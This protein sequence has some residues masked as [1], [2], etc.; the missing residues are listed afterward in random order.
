MAILMREDE[1][2]QVKL[3][4]IK[5]TELANGIFYDRQG[6]LPIDIALSPD[7]TMLAVDLVD[8][9][10]GRVNT[11]INFYNFGSVGQ[12]EVDNNVG[13]FTFENILVP[14][15]DYVSKNKMNGV[16]RRC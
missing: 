4:D 3:F 5:G 15:I 16:L 10:S 6:G 7:A 2:T 13:V 1:K 8:V 14:E 12:S 9:S 11:T